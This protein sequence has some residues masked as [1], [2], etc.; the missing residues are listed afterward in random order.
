M[1][2][3]LED[4]DYLSQLFAIRSLLSRQYQ[5]DRELGD[6]IGEADTLAAQSYGIANAYRVEE[7]VDRVHSSVYQDVA[8][9]MAAVSMI[10]PFI[11]SAF[12]R[13][14]RCMRRKWPE[15][16][17]TIATITTFVDELGMSTYMPDGLD[18]TLQALI[19]YRNKLLHL[20][21]EWPPGERNRFEKRLRTAGWPSDWFDKATTDGDPWMFYMT[22]KFID[23]CV[24]MAEKVIQRIEE[25]ELAQGVTGMRGQ[26][27]GPT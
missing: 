19:E 21:F 3:I 10:A 14:F 13:A 18:L 16:Q 11:E 25:F 2:T 4:F 5:A 7:W 17:S 20:G 12:R 23:H 22:P 24:H 8:H 27:D 1:K 26:S 9:S 15:G 6:K